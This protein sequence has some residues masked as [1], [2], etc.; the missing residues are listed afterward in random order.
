MEVFPGKVDAKFCK[1]LRFDFKKPI[2]E[3]FEQFEVNVTI[4]EIYFFTFLL[5]ELNTVFLNGN[6]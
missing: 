6:F 3:F 1:C 5:L 4:L 2:F